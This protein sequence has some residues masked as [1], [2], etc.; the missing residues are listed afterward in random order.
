MRT[1][2]SGYVIASAVACGVG[3]PGYV[4]GDALAMPVTGRYPATVIKHGGGIFVAGFPTALAATPW[5]S[6]TG[7]R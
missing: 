5:A 3:G 6:S 4:A 1:D 7:R 2:T